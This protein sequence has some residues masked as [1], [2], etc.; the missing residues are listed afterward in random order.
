MPFVD[1]TM[2]F[3]WQRTTY[4]CKVT[5]KTDDDL[6]G[7]SYQ[8]LG[9]PTFRVAVM[10]PGEKYP[11]VYIYWR[12]KSDEIPLYYHAEH[13]KDKQERNIQ[14]A[15]ALGKLVLKRQ[16]KPAVKKEAEKKTAKK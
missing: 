15:E 10:M 7:R 3:T 1:F 14:I 9:W 2:E 5:E 6:A 11:E 16:Q 12:T 4:F 13:K 8:Y